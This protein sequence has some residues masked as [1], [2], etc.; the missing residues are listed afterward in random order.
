MNYKKKMEQ[1]VRTAEAKITPQTRNEI[2]VIREEVRRALNVKRCTRQMLNDF[3]TT[4]MRLTEPLLK[5]SAKEDQ[6]LASLTR[7]KDTRKEDRIA[8]EFARKLGSGT[9]MLQMV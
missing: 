7:H 2:N 5:E 6:I 4:R 3:E 8:S 1:A 9:K